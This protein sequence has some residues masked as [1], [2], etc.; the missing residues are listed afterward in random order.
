MLIIAGAVVGLFLLVIAGLNIYFR[1]SY[2]DFY[3]RAEKQFKIPGLSTGFT[4]QGITVCEDGTFLTCGYMSSK[5][6]SRIYTVSDKEIYV[7]LQKEDGS[8]DTNHTGGLAVY[9][10]FLYLTDGDYI[11]VYLLDDVLK[12]SSGEAV[13]PVYRFSAGLPAA[14]VHVAGD[15]MYVG[16][17]YRSENYPT[18][19]THHMTT[20]AGD[21]HDAVMAVYNLSEGA[22]YG[23][24]SEIPE[25]VYSIT[26]LAQGV[27][28]TDSGRLCVSTSYSIASSNIYIYEDP[29]QYEA[30][31]MFDFA[32]TSVPLYYLDSSHLKETIT[33]F[34]MT[35][36]LT[37]YNGRIYVMCESACNKYIFGK[38]TGNDTL[39]SFQT[40]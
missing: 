12:A 6:A 32:G 22:E 11:S 38:L 2:S 15:R 14:F 36:E 10:D 1:V 23:F 3:A 27:C 24:V 33:L 13:T 18:E 37:S 26:G 29:A 16:E 28:L 17:F 9:G 21:K 7:T 4:P 5:S 25:Y 30:D 39:Y 19:K 20:D 8:A 35:E 34:P 40:E 31:G